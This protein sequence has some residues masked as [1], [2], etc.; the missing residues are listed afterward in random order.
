VIPDYDRSTMHGSVAPPIEPFAAGL[1]GMLPPAESP[2]VPAASSSKAPEPVAS[3][4]GPMVIRVD[5]PS[6]SPATV[7]PRAESAQPAADSQLSAMARLGVTASTRPQSESDDEPGHTS[8]IMP[9]A[10]AQTAS[11]MPP[12]SRTPASMVPSSEGPEIHVGVVSMP[13]L[14]AEPAV[15]V[16]PA[17]IVEAPTPAPIPVR[18]GEP[19][20]SIATPA[21]VLISMS[22]SDAAQPDED[23]GVRHL[24]LRNEPGVLREVCS[25]IVYNRCS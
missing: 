20:P 14:R 16:A 18:I 10:A 9:T 19:A 12:V 6:L 4:R 2:R 11:A 13:H 21:P 24:R 25:P 15:T 22:A 1:L 3:V 5:V 7:M 8:S 17:P 23:S